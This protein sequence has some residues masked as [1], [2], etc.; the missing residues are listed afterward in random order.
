MQQRS[1]FWP[2]LI[3]GWSGFYVMLVELLSGR[4]IAPFFGSS[5]YVWG[6]V[7]FVFMLGLA[8]GYLLGGMYSRHNPSI[9]R[10]CAILIAS[11]TTTLPMLL[12]GEHLLNF[13]FDHITDPRTGSLV[14]CVLLYFVPTVFAGMISPYAIRIIIKNRESSGYDAGY[15]YFVST[16]GS[17]AGT[18]LTSFYFVLWFE[19]N[20]IL[21]A[22]IGFSY[23]LGLL[24]I[25]VNRGKA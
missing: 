6:S 8:V 25:I 19:V 20:M 22:S 18:L 2:L 3:A 9:T 10:L 21:I 5:V 12:F 14:T 15:L 4:F 13:V 17:S 11:A 23:F 24:G 1:T 7:I 16:V